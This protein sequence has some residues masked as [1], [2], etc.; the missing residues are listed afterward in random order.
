[1]FRKAALAKLSSPEQ[2]DTLLQ[3]TKPKSWVALGGCIVLLQAGLVWGVFGRTAERVSG[4]GIL[5]T[6]G[7]VFGVEARGSGIVKEVNVNVGDPIENGQVV[8]VISQTSA[9]EEIRQQEKLLADLRSN[10][11]RAVGLTGKNRDA[12]LRSLREDRVRLSKEA[13]AARAQVK[14]LE[15][16]LRAQQEALRAGLITRDQVQATSQQLDQARSGLVANQAAV[17]QLSAREASALNQADTSQ[18]NLDQEIQRTQH[19][20]ELSKLRYAEG[21]EVK[22]PYSGRVVSRLV[23]PGQEVNPGKAVLYI[24]LTNQPLQAVAFI[25][26]GARIQPG[27]TVQ[28]SPEGITWEEYGYMLGVVEKVAQGPA[29]PDAMTRLLR[30]QT[31]IQQFTAAGGVYEVRVKPLV[32]ASTPSGF[33][34]TSRSGPNLKF[35]SG[36]LLRVQVPVVEKRPIT[37]VI[38]TLRRWLG[39]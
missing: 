30:N 23:D 37:L 21:T 17:T 33:K 10:R 5:L 36:T 19:Q 15:E 8:A 22:S 3:V 9:S 27:M 20:L 24:E 38:P 2:L 14:F 31:L 26:Q 12:E 35:D 13:E 18:F 11:E 32:D 6:E 25:P 39:I 28:M 34:W 29:N 1:M 4:A 16:R 7:G